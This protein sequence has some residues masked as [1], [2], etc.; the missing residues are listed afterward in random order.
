MVKKNREKY[1][2]L[3]REFEKLI[4][5]HG[6]NSITDSQN[7]ILDRALDLFLVEDY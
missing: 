6:T 1:D 2:K 4:K 7:D 5:V 3:D